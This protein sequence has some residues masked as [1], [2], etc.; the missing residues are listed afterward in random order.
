MFELMNEIKHDV[1]VYV[2]IACVSIVIKASCCTP[3]KLGTSTLLCTIMRGA[4]VHTSE[5]RLY[6]FPIG[7]RA[8]RMINYVVV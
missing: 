4:S 7:V 6:C 1:L 5:S 2:G 3:D 8:W